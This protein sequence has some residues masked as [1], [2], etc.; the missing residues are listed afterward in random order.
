MNTFVPSKFVLVCAFLNLI[1]M[2]YQSFYKQT[3]EM[4][5]YLNVFDTFVCC[6]FIFDWFKH[7]LRTDDKK[8]F[9]KWGWLDLLLAIPFTH[10]AWAKYHVVLR[11]VRCVKSLKYIYDYFSK[12][13]K[14]SKFVDCCIIGL[15]FILFSSVAIFNCEKHY[16]DAN[17]KNLSDS[18][19]W[20]AATVTTIGY[21]D[22]YPVSD[23]GRLIGGFVML[24]GVGLYASFTGFIVSKFMSDD[25]IDQMVKD[26]EEMKTLLRKIAEKP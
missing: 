18:L 5:L 26:N 9:L 6:V 3:A 13:D 10:G 19:W 11:L 12:D 14:T 23:I 1:N 16:P 20:A 15:T 8:K 24:C 22:R 25:R 21:G 2:G 7:L 17:I 4:Y